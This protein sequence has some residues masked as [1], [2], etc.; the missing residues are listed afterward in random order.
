MQEEHAE[1]GA[2]CE[3]DGGDAAH[4]GGCGASAADA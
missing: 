2:G 1:S 4:D 3:G